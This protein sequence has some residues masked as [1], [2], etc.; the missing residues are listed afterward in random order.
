MLLLDEIIF[1]KLLEQREF[2][3]DA[4]KQLE[5]QLVVESPDEIDKIKQLQNQTIDQLKSRT[6][7]SISIEF[8]INTVSLSK[9]I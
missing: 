6:R 2:Y 5:F 8:I 3:L 1:E 7:T 4:L 9:A